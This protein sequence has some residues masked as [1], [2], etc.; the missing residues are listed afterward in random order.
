VKAAKLKAR[1]HYWHEPEYY[2]F[3][4]MSPK[5]HK[6]YFDY[7]HHPGEIEYTKCSCSSEDD[8][9]NFYRMKKEAKEWTK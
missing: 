1:G 3:C 9:S 8:E 5:G 4:A 2:N 7:C 6:K